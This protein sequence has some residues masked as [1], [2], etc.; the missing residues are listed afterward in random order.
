MNRQLSAA[1]IRCIELCCELRTAGAPLKLPTWTLELI[2]SV[3]RFSVFAVKAALKAISDRDLRRSKAGPYCDLCE[4]FAGPA[5]VAA[6]R[7]ARK[8]FLRA[9]PIPDRSRRADRR[10]TFEITSHQVT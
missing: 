4:L 9:Q 7:L 6:L 1:S 10:S 8:P 2:G 5:Q 3:D